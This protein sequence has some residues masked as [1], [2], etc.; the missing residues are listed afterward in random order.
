M[1]P[2]QVINENTG[3]LILVLLEVGFW[4]IKKAGFDVQMYES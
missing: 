3:V 2:I 1:N 4:A